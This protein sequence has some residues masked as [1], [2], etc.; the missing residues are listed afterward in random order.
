M[1][2]ALQYG[3]NQFAWNSATIIGLFCGAGATF[4]VFVG[5]E[6]YKGDAAMIP[7]PMLGKRTVWASSLVYGFLMSQMFTTSYYL[8]IYFQGVK[9]VSPTLSGVYLLPMI[10]SQLFLAIG[11]GTLGKDIY[12]PGIVG[13]Y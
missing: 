3:G 6:Y 8:P 2:L 1:L 13:F 10:L 11:A 4:V 5:W 12:T 7:L 9:D